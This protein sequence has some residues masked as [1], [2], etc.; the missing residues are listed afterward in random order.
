MN[1]PSKTTTKNDL[2]AQLQQIGLRALPENLDAFL[3]GASK[4]RW[5]SNM[6]WKELCRSELKDRS[7]RS[8]ERRLRLSAIK[9]FKPLADFEWNWP[10]KIDRDVIERALTLDFL[11]QARNLVLVGRNG[12]GKTLIRSEEG[13][14]GEEGRFRWAA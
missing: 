11:Q 6:L 10:T 13:R 12:L 14:G 4:A 1:S 8:L 3:A 7:R 2:T 9:S 5:P